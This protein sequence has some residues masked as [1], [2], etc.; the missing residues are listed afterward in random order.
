MAKPRHLKN[1][2]I[3]EAIIDLRVQPAHTASANVG[4]TL[5]DRLGERYAFKGPLRIGQIN[6]NP[7]F[8]PTVATQMAG[9]RFHSAGEKFVAQ[10]QQ[11]GFTLSRLA[12]YTS[13]EE[14]TG[15]LRRLWPIYLEVLQPQAIHHVACRYINNLA[16]PMRDGQDFG[17]FLTKSPQVPSALPQSLNGFMQRVMIAY[18][19]AVTV[20]TQLFEPGPTMSLDKVPVLLDID[21][22]C[23]KLLE[24]HSLDLWPCLERLRGLKNDAFFESITERAAELYA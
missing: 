6:F 21:V 23:P 19:D 16:L 17:D 13:W 15:E 10:F 2:P 24:P 8:E 11:Q 5:T 3:T 22:R 20:L 1:A 4:P 9:F 18:P 14:L 12:P 7:E